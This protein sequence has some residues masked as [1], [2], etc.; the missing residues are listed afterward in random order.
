MEFLISILVDFLS[1]AIYSE[2]G[3]S[4]CHLYPPADRFLDWQ[5]CTS[6]DAWHEALMRPLRRSLGVWYDYVLLEWLLLPRCG[7]PDCVCSIKLD[8]LSC[9]QLLQVL[10]LLR[11][12]RFAIELS[13]L[14]PGQ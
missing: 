4:G 7:L 8:L 11:L 10:P 2:L 5:G 1:L 14:G 6:L 9:V 3:C 12:D 13:E